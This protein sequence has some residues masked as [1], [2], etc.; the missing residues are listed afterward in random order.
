MPA[1]HE[2]HRSHSIPRRFSELPPQAR[3]LVMEMHRIHYGRFEGLHVNNGQP[4][5]VPPPLL[6]KVKRIGSAEEFAS[7]VSDD[8]FLKEPILD[9]LS[10]F[11]QLGS[12]IIERLEFRR[13]LP[14]LLEFSISAANDSDR[15]GEIGV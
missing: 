14:C 10:E 6:F 11:A 15:A 8:W 4:I 3:V 1:E 13:G 2:A 7:P 5:F 9:L 12:G